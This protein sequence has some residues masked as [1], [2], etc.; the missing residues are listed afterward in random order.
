MADISVSE[1][2]SQ[3]NNFFNFIRD[4]RIEEEDHNITDEDIRFVKE[5]LSQFE[6][7]KFDE[8]N[9]ENSIEI[10]SKYLKITILLKR[11]DNDIFYEIFDNIIEVFDE[12]ILNLNDTNID[13]D[14]MTIL[15]DFYLLN[16]EDISEKFI[17]KMFIFCNN[18]NNDIELDCF[19]IIISKC[20]D[21]NLNDSLI[22]NLKI[23]FEYALDWEGDII[24]KYF[25]IIYKYN[26]SLLFNLN[27]EVLEILKSSQGNSII[28]SNLIQYYILHKDELLN[29]MENIDIF[30][31]NVLYSIFYSQNPFVLELI[32]KNFSKDFYAKLNINLFEKILEYLNGKNLDDFNGYFKYSIRNY[33]GLIYQKM[34]NKIGTS[35][36]ITTNETCSMCY[37]ESSEKMF[38]TTCNHK[39]CDS[40]IKL[41]LIYNIFNQSGYSCPYCRK[42]YGRILSLTNLKIR[43]KFVFN[44][45]LKIIKNNFNIGKTL[46]RKNN[47]Y[48]IEIC[49]LEVHDYFITIKEYF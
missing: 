8:L 4:F 29:E 1:N 45:L 36:E 2:N 41:N 47:K 10:I 17:L 28:L 34:Y 19:E 16:Y 13:I 21:K 37:E 33:Y 40:C 22:S 42:N 15:I 32:L 35:K 5:F 39:F 11:S 38:I 12:I 6:I 49:S 48:N 3:I 9:Y 7:L 31:N 23:L 24:L 18:S 14:Y 30:T 26:K 44:D 27:E 20:I 43:D 25:Q 46:F